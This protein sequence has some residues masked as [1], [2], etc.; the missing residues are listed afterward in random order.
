MEKTNLE[1]IIETV[2][3]AQTIIRREEIQNLK[4]EREE[5]FKELALREKTI[6][7]KS[8]QSGFED[9]QEDTNE[10]CYEDGRSDG[11]AEGYDEG[12]YDGYDEGFEDAKDQFLIKEEEE[13]EE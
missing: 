1:T 11:Y 7:E 10:Y 5:L 8:Y 3:V 13:K 9:G 4:D 12:L 2:L 6:G